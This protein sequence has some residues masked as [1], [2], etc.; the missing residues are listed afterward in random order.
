MSDKV[1]VTITVSA[2]DDDEEQVS[3]KFGDCNLSEL[4]KKNDIVG[5]VAR[6]F[7]DAL[8]EEA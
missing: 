3:V 4:V 2:V 1:N 8:A 7:Q 5:V 6:T